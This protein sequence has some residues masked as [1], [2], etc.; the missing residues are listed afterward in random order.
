M[1]P[2]KWPLE[3]PNNST[4]DAVSGVAVSIKQVLV[5]AKSCFDKKQKEARLPLLLPGDRDAPVGG[6]R[7]GLS[8]VRRRAWGVLRCHAAIRGKIKKDKKAKGDAGLIQPHMIPNLPINLWGKDLLGQMNVYMIKCKDPAVI[9]QMI[10]QGYGLDKG[11]GN[12]L[13]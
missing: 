5:S 4:L 7:G 12:N 11:L 13:Q 8:P 2:T 1:S 3:W 10:S 6:G 9:Q